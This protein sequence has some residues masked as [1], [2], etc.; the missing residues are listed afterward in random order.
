MAM[1]EKEMLQQLLAGMRAHLSSLDDLCD[2]AKH[3]LT[4]TENAYSEAAANA[5]AHGE[6]VSEV[7]RQRYAGLISEAQE[8]LT[9]AVTGREAFHAKLQQLEDRIAKL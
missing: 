1:A 4:H 3:C 6:A 7:E 8:N 2:S 5:R 9:I